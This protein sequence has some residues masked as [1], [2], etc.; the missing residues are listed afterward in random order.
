MVALR[1]MAIRDVLGSRGG[2]LAVGLSAQDV[3]DRIGSAT[4]DAIS[5]AADNGAR[6]V[7]LSGDA[8]ALD[9]LAAELAAEDVRVKRVPVDYASHSAQ[10]D[11]LRERLLADLAPIVPRAGD[12]PMMSTVTGAWVDGTSLDAAYWF[13]NLRRTVRFAPVVRELAGQGH[14]TFVEVSPHPVIA[15]SIQETLDELDGA[16]VVTGTLRRDDGG[17]DRFATSV[18]ELYVRGVTVDWTTF[19]PG[20]T[21]V[22][23]PTYPFQRK[24]FWSRQEPVA[25]MSTVDS[26]RYR[27]SWQPVTPAG[28]PAGG[29]LVVVPEGVPRAD[30]IADELAGHGFVRTTLAELDGLHELGGPAERPEGVVSLLAL[31]RDGTAATIALLRAVPDVPVWCVTSR[32]VAVDRFEDVDPAASSLWGMGTVLG[33]DRG[34]TWGMIDVAEGAP[35][36]RILAVVSGVDGEDQVAIRRAGTFARRLVRAPR[37]DPGSWRPYGTVLVTG[38]TGAIGSKVARW[39]AGHGAEHVVLTSRRGRAAA[40]AAD[41]EAELRALGASVTIAACDVSDGAA[42]SDLLGSLPTPSAVFHAAGVL[43]DE[44]PITEVTPEEFAAAVRAKIDGAA[45]L[46]RLLGEVPL[47]FFSS[48]AA[49]WGTSGQPAY[50]AANAFLDGLAQHRRAR[51]LPATSVAWG[52]WAGGGMVDETASAQLRRIGLSEMDPALALDALEQALAHDESHLV[53]AD[54]DWEKFAPVYTVA[55]QR[56][57]LRALPEVD[58]ILTEQSGQSG[59][60]PGG[61]EFAAKLRAL[62]TQEQHRLLLD[63]VRTHVAGVLGHDGAAAVEPD[64]AFKDLGFD[65]VT[66]VDLRNRLGTA[67]GLRLRTTVVFDHANPKALAEHLWTRL[68]RDGADVPLAVELDRIEARVSTLS[69]DEIESSRLSARLNAL[70]TTVNAALGAADGVADRIEAAS[71]DDLFALIDNELGD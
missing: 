66:A 47:V 57:L 15:M 63:L 43:A 22:D 20:G 54:I 70:L 50:A 29:W 62:T 59:Q 24:R 4:S 37:G 33:L 61:D 49:V 69:R 28:R 9:A 56:P 64:R 7:V 51:G 1:S 6:S 19:L 71:V 39:L 35:V 38:G 45:H 26:W 44:P 13:D 10:V 12:V 34:R 27:V 21:V 68:C 65:S 46:D 55:R 32:A 5:I 48:G 3:R 2:M 16:S 18:A 40:G 8:E 41:L 60:D 23:L 25:P 30:A 42:L 58:R 17:T 31:G 53:V 67:C 14:A 52:S 36:E 11:Q